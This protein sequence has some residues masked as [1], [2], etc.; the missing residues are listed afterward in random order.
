MS[1]HPSGFRSSTVNAVE[2]LIVRYGS[3]E[4]ARALA[5]ERLAYL[6]WRE[7][8]PPSTWERLSD[9]E[10][11]QAQTERLDAA[12]E[13]IV[14]AHSQGLLS[15]RDYERLARMVETKPE[16]ERTTA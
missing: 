7:A 8:N 10:A 6:D 2:A 16:T 15:H 9:P 5:Q 1:R 4:R 3:V 11:A 13:T 14:L 12:V